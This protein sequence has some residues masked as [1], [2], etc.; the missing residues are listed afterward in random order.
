LEETVR[1][2]GKP[3]NLL[4]PED[5]QA[6]EYKRRAPTAHAEQPSGILECPGTQAMAIGDL[7]DGFD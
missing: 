4:V 3:V 7:G 1:E 6:R 5:P 2:R